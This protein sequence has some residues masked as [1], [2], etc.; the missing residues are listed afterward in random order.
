M[1]GGQNGVLLY[2]ADKNNYDIFSIGN[3][4]GTVEISDTGCTISI[5]GDPFIINSVSFPNVE[6]IRT[7]IADG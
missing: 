1:I 7:V 6:L 5:L 3:S 4:W 2:C